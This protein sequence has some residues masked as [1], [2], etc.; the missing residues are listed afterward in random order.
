MP[1][2]NY[3]RFLPTAI[4]SVLNQ[5]YELFELIV[6][7]N[8][9]T[10]GSYEI[11]L[12]Y[13]ERD[14]RI[15]VLTHAGRENRGVNA[16]LN[17]GVRE[18]GGEYFGL[19][20]ADDLY[21]PDGL[22]RRVRLLETAPEA[23]FAYGRAQLI[24]ETGEPTGTIGGRSPEEMVGFDATGDLLQALL[25][26]DFV[27]GAAM[28]TRRDLLIA[29]GGFD[30]AVF[31]N[32]WYVAMRLLARARCLFVSG[33]PVVG[34]R[35]HE[36]HRSEENR[37]ADR[38]RR[39][40]LFRALS[41][42]AAAADDDLAK[43][44]V[45]ALIALQLAVHA[46]R[47]GELGEARTAVADAFTVDPSLQDDAAYIAWWLDPRHGEW[48]LALS[49]DER[50]LFLTS[51]STPTGSFDGVLAAGSDYTVFADLVLSAAADALGAEARTRIA[52]TVAAEQLEAVAAGPQIGVLASALIRAVRRPSL[53]RL[54]P[55]IKTILCAAGLWPL[56]AKLRARRVITIAR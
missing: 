39:L 14:A 40:E 8:G 20:P 37:D 47:L 19:L 4:E 48:S 43:P 42:H 5:S 22:E 51:L 31:F 15:R 34:Y 33:E 24:D 11:A 2:Y 36:R 18:A 44:R 12:D 27:P 52:W 6:V 45:R 50:R 7:D 35:L 30:E 32:D 1:S 26:H 10:D 16:S 29:I 55:F 25:F 17:L 3:A 13:A 21:L 41:A 28:L 53:L 38:P 54:R 49:A 46:Y 56:A 9:S 23:G